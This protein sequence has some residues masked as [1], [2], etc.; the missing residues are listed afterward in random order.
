MAIVDTPKEELAK[1]AG[2]HINLW[3]AIVM[4]V[5][6]ALFLLWVRLR[7]QIAADADDADADDRPPAHH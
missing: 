2:L 3:S 5:V 7:P 1:S 4:L 6:A